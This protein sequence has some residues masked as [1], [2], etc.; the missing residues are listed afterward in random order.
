MMKTETEFKEWLLDKMDE[1]VEGT[2]Q[3]S[4]E[5]CPLCCQPS[6]PVNGDLE[7]Y[8][9]IEEAGLEPEE[10][11]INHYDTCLISALDKYY[12][13]IIDNGLW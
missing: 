11:H 7:G 4:D 1:I 3:M 13:K 10:Y 2:A 5:S 12:L 8:K 6:Y 9:E